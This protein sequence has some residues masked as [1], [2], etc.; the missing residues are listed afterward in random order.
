[1][2]ASGPSLVTTSRSASN[3]S[4][5]GELKPMNNSP[6]RSL[7]WGRQ[8]E[9]RG[10][11]ATGSLPVQSWIAFR[12]CRGSFFEVRSPLRARLPYRKSTGQS[13]GGFSLSAASCFVALSRG[14]RR[15][16][17]GATKP[18]GCCISGR[19]GLARVAKLPTPTVL[20]ALRCLHE[21]AGSVQSRTRRLF[22]VPHDAASA[23]PR[24]PA[25]EAVCFRR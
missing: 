18:D 22:P 8:S 9:V 1:M 2:P 20:G 14:C 24:R 15:L 25:E 12:S 11:I 10:S 5:A 3:A 17:P 21:K 4:E 23:R 19:R 16:K 7:K 6:G 13:G